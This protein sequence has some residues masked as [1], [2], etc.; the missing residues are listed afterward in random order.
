MGHGARQGREYVP[1]RLTQGVHCKGGGLSSAWRGGQLQWS[2]DDVFPARGAL[3]RLPASPRAIFQGSTCWCGSL[4]RSGSGASSV[5]ALLLAGPCCWSCWSVVEIV[6]PRRAR[7]T[8]PDWALAAAVPSRTPRSV[9][10]AAGLP[11]APGPAPGRP[12][13][14]EQKGRAAHLAKLDGALMRYGQ[15]TSRPLLWPAGLLQIELIPTN[16]LRGPPYVTLVEGRVFAPPRRP[17]APP[18]AWPH[19]PETG[20]CGRPLGAARRLS[21]GENT[22]P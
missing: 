18:T 5:S 7:E 1:L 10:H 2:V 17:P 9:P 15:L 4:M 19:S 13:R 14:T 3:P 8:A 16:M 11:R 22:R 12:I 20:E 6:S 21:G